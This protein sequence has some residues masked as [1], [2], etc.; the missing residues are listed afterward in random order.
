MKSATT[1]RGTSSGA[2]HE[3]ATLAGGCFWCL[4][5]IFQRVRGVETVRSGYCGGTTADPGYDEVCTGTTGHA[6][7]VQIHFDPQLISYAELLEIFFAIHD[8]TTPNRQGHDIGTQYRSAIF[9]HS[10]AQTACAHASIAAHAATHPELKPIVT[11]VQPATTFFPAE[12][13]H[14]NY[15]SDNRAAPYCQAVIF[16]KLAKFMHQFR[17]HSEPGAKD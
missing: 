9:T 7:A 13:H 11:E 6:E 14:Q 2:R 15:F 16:P 10:A 3:I 5:A 12:E 8:P 1:E 4:E 17:R